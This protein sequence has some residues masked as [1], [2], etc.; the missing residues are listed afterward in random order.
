M[1]NTSWG[2][3]SFFKAENPAKRTHTYT[4]CVQILQFILTLEQVVYEGG[5]QNNRN[6]Y[7]KMVY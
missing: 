1:F 7:F 5:P 6:Y 4:F 3:G 2:N